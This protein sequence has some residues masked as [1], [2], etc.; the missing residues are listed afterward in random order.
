MTDDQYML[1][2]ASYVTFLWM[3]LLSLELLQKDRIGPT[4]NL[5]LLS[6]ARHL[7]DRSAARSQT[8][9]VNLPVNK[10]QDNEE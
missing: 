5:T 10:L 1:E 4:C 7:Q 3:F 2:N 6:L 8:K 9:M